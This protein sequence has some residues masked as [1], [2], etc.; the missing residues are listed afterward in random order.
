MTRIISAIIWI[1]VI[2]GFAVSTVYGEAIIMMDDSGGANYTSIQDAVN[3]ANGGAK[4]LVH[5]GTYTEN[6]NVTKPLTTQSESRNPDDAVVLAADPDDHVFYVTADNVTISGFGVAGS[7]NHGIYLE[8]VGGCVIASNVVS[9]NRYGIGMENSDHNDLSNNTASA[10]EWEG[11][12][13]RHSRYNTLSNNNVFNNK[14]N[15]LVW[16]NTS[17]TILEV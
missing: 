12:I 13:L 16:L 11:I 3:N 6:V 17:F 4:I 7:N 9:N 8:E 10:N 14:G 2:S 1:L 5:T 15:Y